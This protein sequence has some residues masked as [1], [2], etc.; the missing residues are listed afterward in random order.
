MAKIR[1]TNIK[2]TYTG[3]C[4]K[5]LITD[6][7]KEYIIRSINQKNPYTGEYE[8]EI[9]E[10]NTSSSEIGGLAGIL[11]YL[12]FGCGGMIFLMGL[13]FVGNGEWG[14]VIAG[15][16]LTIVPIIIIFTAEKYFSEKIGVI[17]LI[18]IIIIDIIVLVNMFSSF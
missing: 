4:Q 2:D 8:K 16:L 14:Y 11:F 7:G 1:D 18:A 17:C 13:L 12:L 10:K 15:A 3:D 5:E 6:D 9:I